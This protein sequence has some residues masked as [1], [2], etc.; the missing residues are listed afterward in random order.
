VG[1]GDVCKYSFP[2]YLFSGVNL[3][4]PG[5]ES[6]EEKQQ[7]KERDRKELN[8]KNAKIEEL[9]ISRIESANN[10][11]YF[12][13]E[14]IGASS[15]SYEIQQFFEEGKE[16][17]VVFK[18]F[19]EDIEKT[20]T[21][22]LVDLLTPLG[23]NFIIDNRSVLFR[24]VVPEEKLKIFLAGKRKDPLAASIRYYFGADYYIVAAISSA[25]RIRQ[26]EYEGASE[27]EEVKI[28]VD[29]AYSIIAEGQLINVLKIE[30]AE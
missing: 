20:E 3:S 1:T 17:P 2:N 21:G 13:P 8:S 16:K 4:V 5:G 14:T 10:A 26:Y 11:N 27:G 22:I 9:K 15:Y 24:L 25:R 18:A 12:P 29:A 30:K 6:Y 7:K 23:R 28:N 19:L